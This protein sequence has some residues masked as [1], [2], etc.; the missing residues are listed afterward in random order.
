MS[1]AGL[2]MRDA[3]RLAS[4]FS[5]GWATLAPQGT[6]TLRLPML[7]AL[8]LQALA[9]LRRLAALPV[10]AAPA[11]RMLAAPALRMLAAP[12]LPVLAALVLAVGLPAPAGAEVLVPPLTGHVTD[13]TG[14]LTGEQKAALEQT[15]AAFEAQ[16]G[17]QIAVL[18]VAT[19]APESIEQYSLRVVEK[20]K[21]GRKKVDDG[22]LLLVAKNDRG[23]RIEVGYG[24][25]GALND[26]TCKRIIAETITPQFKQGDYYQ[27]ISDGVASMLKVVGGEPLPPP[28]A[29]A[30][31]GNGGSDFES[32]LPIVFIFAVV[33]GGIL[34]SIFGRLAGSVL[35][36]G[37]TG[38]IA[39]FVAGALSMA[40]IAGVI[41]M[42]IT[43]FSG[44][45]GSML[46][47]GYGGRGGGGGGG[48]YSGGGGGFGG[49]G[50]SGKW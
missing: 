19:T 24:L 2:L 37:I 1:L 5:R 38:L 22:A 8:R 10:L 18:I 47:G 6:A 40:L 32:Y 36:G 39:F 7:A 26:A 45:I 23:M 20:W 12:A 14:T 44:G 15:L 29:G 43:L 17:S 16:K 46:G 3:G 34:R 50:A 13:Q 49:G 35:A 28:K 42:L 11:L 48:G 25:E 41:A 27:G 4:A 30:A 9:A 31:R 33:V 21:L